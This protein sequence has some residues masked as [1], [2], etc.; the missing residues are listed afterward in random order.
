MIWY[1][2]V[3]VIMT[4]AIFLLIKVFG[5]KYSV[6]AEEEKTEAAELKPPAKLTRTL[7][8]FPKISI[9]ISAL[10]VL[11]SVYSYYSYANLPPNVDPNETILTSDISES[12][13]TLI[14]FVLLIITGITYLRWIYRTNKNLRAF[15]GEHMM[16]TPGWSVGWYFIPIAFLYKPYQGMKEIWQV[17]H[18]NRAVTYSI[19]RWWWALFLISSFLDRLASKFATIGGDDVAGYTTSAMVYAVSYGL[20][21]I[22][23]IVTFMLVTRIGMAYS[24]N[25]T[26]NIEDVNEEI[27]RL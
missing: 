10:A 5:N 11:T 7:C 20:D 15:S 3:P 18:K 23:Y 27:T 9:A 1:I 8:I 6:K 17:S 12:L 16:F 24:R 22:V 2:I 19:V 4:I 13:V 26:E 21:V 25:I 14:Q